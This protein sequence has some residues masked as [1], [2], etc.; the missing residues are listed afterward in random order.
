MT[1]HAEDPLIAL[2]R[3]YRPALMA[4]FVRRIHNPIEAEDLTQ[5]VLMRL[6]ELPENQ[7]RQ[8]E[9]YIFRMAANLLRDRYRRA[10]VRD[11]WA[12]D[13][14]Q[15]DER[16]TDYIDPLRLIEARER[17]GLVSRALSELSQRS[18]EILLL[19]RLER[20]KKREIAESFGISVSAVDKHIIRAIAHLTRC[21]E[22]EA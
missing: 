6:A 17:L 15:R 16:L 21:L 2:S 4:F 20:M 14:E 12:L 9:G 19:F 8:P 11:A 5:D 13:A 7:M 18:R 3:R 22:D 1:Q 10:R